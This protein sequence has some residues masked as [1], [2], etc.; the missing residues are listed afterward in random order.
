MTQLTK[1][2]SGYPRI[3]ER[4]IK[5]RLKEENIKMI[6]VEYTDLNG[7]NRSKLLPV[8]MI[9]HVFE[10]GISFCTAIMS[11]SFDNKIAEVDYI[12]ENNY[13]D[14]KIFADPSTFKILPHIDNT[15]LLLGDLYHNGEKM[16]QSP[17]WFLKRMIREYQKLG[18]NPI[19]ANELE[20]FLFNRKKDGGFVPYTNKAGNCYTSDYRIDPNQFLG[21]MTETFKEMDFQV[22]Y[23]NHEFYPG[24]YEYNWKHGSVLRN[25][26]EGVLFKGIS[27][28]IAHQNNLFI[29][30]MAKP[31]DDNGGSGGHFH[32]SIEDIVSG[33]N[34]FYDRDKEDGMSE[35]MHNFAAGILKHA[36]ALT[37]FLAPTINCYKRF[38]PNSFA[39]YYI[40][41]GYDNRT[42]FLRVPKERG[43][44]T[45]L[46][47]RA[48][49]AAANPY[50]ALASILAAGL[51]GIKNELE[52]EPISEE[53][54]YYQD[55]DE[56]ERVPKSL[57]LALAALKKDQW[58]KECAGHDLVDNFVKLK[59]LEVNKFFNS[60]TDWEWDFYAYHV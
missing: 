57:E 20:F 6:R 25:A 45:R 60:V 22:L 34:L 18:Y 55:I 2:T 1:Q 52:P 35:L 47:V 12:E 56:R 5:Y 9:D 31:L 36:K 3:S 13:D 7:V 11:M 15:A 14:F 48:G 54:L 33:E 38:Q 50:L 49:S 59:E 43:G 10:E 46:E 39:P 23:M 58:L 37:A 8:D 27:K 51:D 32:F 40:G 19:S 44:A 16:K 17:R 29:T 30:Y 28:E 4:Y 26:D 42:A 24:Q 41:W 53:D 21:K